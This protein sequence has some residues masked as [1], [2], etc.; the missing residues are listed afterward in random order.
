MGKALSL[1]KELT[2]AELALIIKIGIDMDRYIQQYDF[3]TKVQRLLGELKKKQFGIQLFL[4]ANIFDFNPRAWY[5]PQNLKRR[6]ESHMGISDDVIDSRDINKALNKLQDKANFKNITGM[7]EI[8]RMT[9]KNMQFT[10]FPSVW[11]FPDTLNIMRGILSKPKIFKTIYHALLNSGLLYD[12]WRHNIAQLISSFP[13]L[14]KVPAFSSIVVPGI[15]AKSK[16]LA[17]L[18]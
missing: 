17:T 8:K 9:H 12:F 18:V 6:F 14:A 11:K 1:N 10:G 16:N 15:P 2:T 7:K 3:N 4:I 13:L 5:K